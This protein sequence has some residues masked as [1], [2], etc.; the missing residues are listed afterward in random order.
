[1]E[2]K[3]DRQI[4][5]IQLSDRRTKHISKCM[6][7]LRSDC[8]HSTTMRATSTPNTNTRCYII[9]TIIIIDTI[10]STG[11]MTPSTSSKIALA[12]MIRNHSTTRAHLLRPHLL[13]PRAQTPADLPQHVF[14]QSLMSSFTT[15][16]AGASLP[17]RVSA[18]RF[19]RFRINPREHATLMKSN[20]E[21]PSV[22]VY[23]CRSCRARE[24]PPSEGKDTAS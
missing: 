18:L 11:S 19:F 24:R 2:V 4:T 1:M 7:S 6:I 5:E 15:K 16:N 8:T 12:S 13:H 3:G 14:A 20:V 21:P 9:C 17:L 22:C 10:N 23:C